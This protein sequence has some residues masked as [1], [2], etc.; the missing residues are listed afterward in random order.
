MLRKH[1]TAI[2]VTP[3]VRVL[4][5]FQNCDWI[6]IDSGYHILVEKGITPLFAIGDFD[7]EE[8]LTD[9]RTQKAANTEGYTFPFL[10]YPV[11]K[12]ETDSE[13]ALLKAAE[14]GYTTI[15]LYGGLEGR[16]D[17]TIA[18]L[19][20]MCWKVPQ[21]IAMDAWHK[22]SVLLPGEYTIDAAYPHISFFAM[23]P[24]VITL[25]G[26]DYPLSHRTIDQTEFYTCSNS[27]S[28]QDSAFAIVEKG[29]VLCVQSR[30]P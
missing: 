17:H 30:K 5:D 19:R 2:L 13:I 14:M 20:C 18:N 24:S 27:I 11:A 6:G 23:E 26:F 16:L 8:D 22:V 28:H 9:A 3:L 15:I 25:D 29:R 7:S 1:D 21:A 12:N 10:R 4:P